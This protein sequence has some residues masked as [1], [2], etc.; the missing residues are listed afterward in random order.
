M[1]N[2]GRFIRQAIIHNYWLKIEYKNKNEE[3]TKYMIGINNINS[4]TKKMDVDCFNI[5][6]SDK[7]DLRTI[8]YDNILSVE[9]CENTYHKTPEWFL[10]NYLTY[11]NF[12]SFLNDSNNNIN[13]LDYYLDC[14]K[15]DTVPYI[16]NYSLVSG[17]DKEVIA[18]QK[19]YKLDDEKFKKLTEKIFNKT[20]NSKNKEKGSFEIDIQLAMNVLS[21]YD[22]SKGLYVLAYKPL[23]LDIKNKTL[24]ALGDVVVNKEFAYDKNT[25]DIKNKDSVSK[26]LPEDEL[27]LLDKFEENKD[28]ILESIH[29]YNDTKN[30]TYAKEIKT[31]EKPYIF[32]LAKNIIVDLNNEFIGIKKMIESPDEYMTLP[33]KAFLGYSDIKKISRA[34]MPVFVIREKYDID[35]INAIHNGMKSYISYIQGP[36][37]TGKTNTILNAI[38]TAM[39]NGK[40]VLITSNNNVPMDGVYDDILNLEYRGEQLL[41]PAIR[42]GNNE[43]IYEA[44]DRIRNM[45]EASKHLTPYSNRINE[46]KQERKEALSQLVELLNNYENKQELIKRKLNLEKIAKGINSES[47]KIISKSQIDNVDKEIEKIG[48]IDLENFKSLMNIDFYSLK[49][50]IHY[51]TAQRLQK[52]ENPKYSEILNIANLPDE[53][54]EDKIEKIKTFKRY[55]GEDANFKKFQ[56]IFPVIIST[57]LSCTYLG[58]PKEQFDIVMMDEA[59]QC[60]IANALIPI[61]RAKQLMLVGDPQQL[62]PVVVLDENINKALMEKYNIPK[63][64]DYI[65]NSIY[66]AFTTIDVENRETLLSHH[67]RCNEKI[68]NFSNKKYYNNMLKIKT[69]SN[70]KVPLE[71]YDTSKYDKNDNTYCKNI[72]RPEAE[73]IVDYIQSHPNQSI[74]IITPF[75]KQKEC[76]ENYIKSYKLNSEKIT[77]GT[78][79]AY[80]GNEKEIIIFSTAIT[81]KTHEK[82]YNWLKNN[83]EL[84]NVAVTRAKNK[85]IMLGNK[86]VIENLDTEDNDLK[87]LAKYI[88]TNGVSDVTNSSISS[89]ALGT[90]QIST[91]S[92]LDFQE[93]INQVLSVLDETCYIKEEVPIA[94]VFVNDNVNSQLFYMQRFDIVVFQKCYGGDK[95]LLILELNGPEH[96]TKQD[97]IERDNVK[98]R[99]CEEHGIKLLNVSRDCARDYY[100]IKNDIKQLIKVKK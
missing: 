20:N 94:S 78:V 72:S 46:I 36:P 74:G 35:Q 76:I 97:V 62:K 84:I 27:Y 44:L 15:L 81:N 85:L 8:F 93:T 52:L 75:V 56:D 80:Q 58:T 53:N 82:T 54:P 90:R 64:Y 40:T 13:I 70:E 19:T 2:K 6:Y 12:Y 26:F 66:T 1:E 92:E 38:I 98:K 61:V 99:L 91:E 63:E 21:I 9:I 51:E 5:M 37:G 10:K 59:G 24:V 23:K 39:F 18:D 71:F 48:N 7:V 25:G 86:D 83:K 89:E 88:Q 30:S 16:S 32:S 34:K 79:H 17:L 28:K 67:Y 50:A 4:H 14:H 87:E 43:N 69:N 31:D 41:F 77:V 96:S 3:I 11:P 73:F 33:I 100:S 68:I 65:N 45:Y 47:L 60:S 22:Q 55:L 42:L 29:L 95:I 57:N 49:M